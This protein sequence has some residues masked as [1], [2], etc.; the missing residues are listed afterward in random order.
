MI[1]WTIGEAQP[2]AF[3]GRFAGKERF[4]NTGE[5]MRSDP[6]AGVFDLDY[7]PLAGLGFHP[8]LEHEDFP[9]RLFIERLIFGDLAERPVG[10]HGMALRASR[11][12]FSFPLV[13]GIFWRVL[14]QHQ[15]GEVLR[16]LAPNRCTLNPRERQEW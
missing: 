1:P 16:M 3:V 6:G 14:V 11:G 8:G 13:W 4:P 9:D 7:H 12:A 2:S 5:D 10:R 15:I